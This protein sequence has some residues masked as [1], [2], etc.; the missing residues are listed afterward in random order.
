MGSGSIYGT[1]NVSTL[2][3]AICDRNYPEAVPGGGHSP[4]CYHEDMVAACNVDIEQE[5]NEVAVVVLAQAVVH[6]WTVV[7]W[8]DPLVRWV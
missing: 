5:S 1:E 4:V 8:D 2:G 6:P 3:L 7:I